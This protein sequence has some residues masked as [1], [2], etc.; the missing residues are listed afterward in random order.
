VH[1]IQ[2]NQTKP[3]YEDEDQL[4]QEQEVIQET[5]EITTNQVF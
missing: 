5:G 4:E 1:E 3:D 2:C